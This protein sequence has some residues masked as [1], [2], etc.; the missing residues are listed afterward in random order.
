MMVTGLGMA[1]GHHGGQGVG[2]GQ[3]TPWWPQGIYGVGH[4]WVTPWGFQE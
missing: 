4:G 2:H 3:V 1:R